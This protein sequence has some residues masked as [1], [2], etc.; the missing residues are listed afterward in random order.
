MSFCKAPAD[1]DKNLTN[2]IVHSTPVG[3]LLNA[4]EATAA[5]LHANGEKFEI[6]AVGGFVSSCS[7]L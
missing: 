2:V 3:V 7:V 5:I 1:T 4:L 6:V